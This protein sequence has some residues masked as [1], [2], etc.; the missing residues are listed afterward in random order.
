MSLAN[1]TAL[2]TGGGTGIGA[3]CAVAL[4]RAGCAVAIAGRRANKL[5]EAARLFDGKPAI[6]T[7]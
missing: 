5:A 2:I 6:K 7:H 1:K 3:G 4:A